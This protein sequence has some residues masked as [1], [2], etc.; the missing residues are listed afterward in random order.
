LTPVG[1]GAFRIG[2][3]TSPERLRFSQMVGGRALCANLS[4]SDYYR[5]FVP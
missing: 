3:E 5:F 1:E 4:G 2:D